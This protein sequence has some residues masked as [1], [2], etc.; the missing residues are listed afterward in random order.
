M[1]N[2]EHGLPAEGG[3]S[4]M[5]EDRNP[6]GGKAPKEVNEEDAPVKGS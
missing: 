5:K 1:E 2:R 4:Q 3:S 6:T